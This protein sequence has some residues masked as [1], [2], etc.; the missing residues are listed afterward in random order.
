MKS[1]TIPI[2]HLTRDRLLFEGLPK[3]NE[4]RG[5]S[6]YTLK[7]RD[8]AS[9]DATPMWCKCK[10]ETF[11]D[12]PFGICPSLQTDDGNNNNSNKSSPSWE[13]NIGEKGWTIRIKSYATPTS[14]A[15]REIGIKTGNVEEEDDGVSELKPLSPEYAD[16]VHALEEVDHWCVE[17]ISKNAK[18]PIPQMWGRYKYSTRYGNKQQDAKTHFKLRTLSDE[19]IKARDEK[20][21]KE[22]KPPVAQRADGKPPYENVTTKFWHLEDVETKRMREMTPEEAIR[23]SKGAKVSLTF[24]VTSAYHNPSG[25]VT[26]RRAVDSVVFAVLGTDPE[27]FTSAPP[28]LDGLDLTQFKRARV[29]EDDAGDEDEEAE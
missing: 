14:D 22:G 1:K 3:K 6:T 4:R 5:D 19:Q 2:K 8:P 28:E 11:I 12:L 26:L 10:M 21:A 27:T 9:A 18:E 16:L 20:L 17:N 13:L 23:H 15:V 24:T 29:E 25:T 7:H